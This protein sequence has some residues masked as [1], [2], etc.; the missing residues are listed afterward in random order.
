MIDRII[1]LIDDYDYALN[2]VPVD[3]AVDMIIKR[4]QRSRAAIA[5]AVAAAVQAASLLSTRFVT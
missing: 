3:D 1:K 2:G 5:A 4:E